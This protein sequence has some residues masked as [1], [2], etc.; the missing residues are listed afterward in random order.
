[1]PPKSLRDALYARLKPHEPPPSAEA[2]FLRRAAMEFPTS[3]VEG[4]CMGI[5]IALTYR[6]R[7]GGNPAHFELALRHGDLDDTLSAGKLGDLLAALGVP[8]EA[9]RPGGWQWSEETIADGTACI[10]AS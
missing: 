2:A 3:R 10:T 6:P 7:E 5:A 4:V 8:P 1:M 9:E